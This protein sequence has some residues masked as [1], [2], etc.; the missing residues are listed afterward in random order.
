MPQKTSRYSLS[1]LLMLVCCCAILLAMTRSAFQRW[2]DVEVGLFCTAI[3]AAIGAL[4]GIFVGVWSTRWFVGGVLGLLGGT[5]VGGMSG[6]QIA[7]PPDV[8][9]VLLGMTILLVMSIVLRP[10]ALDVVPY[11][12]PSQITPNATRPHPTDNDPA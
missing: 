7:A 10:V 11:P 2:T 3:G 12:N 6:A 8:V 9:V 1:S 5:L 4:I